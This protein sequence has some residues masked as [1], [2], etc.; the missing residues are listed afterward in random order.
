MDSTAD[1]PAALLERARGAHIEFLAS[2]EPLRPQLYRYCRRLTGNIWDAQDLVQETL[3][4]AFAHAAQSHRPVQRPMA[5]L[6][7]IA[8]NIYIDTLRSAVPVPAELPERA[9]PT[10]T[11]PLE[12]RDALAELSRLLSPQEKACVLLKDVFDLPAK[13]IAAMLSTTQGAVKAALHRGRARLAQEDR[14]SALAARP[15]PDPVVLERLAEAF[16]AYDLDRLAALFQDDAVSEV[17]GVVHEVGLSEIRAGSLQH[18]LCEE[19]DV[20]YRAEVGE[21]EREPV[22]LLWAAPVDGSAGEALVDVL[23]VETADDAVTRLRW[24]FFCPETLVEVAALIRGPV[25]THG[26]HY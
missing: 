1:L 10:D 16:S 15:A 4:R 23:R 18:T 6:A 21:I 20:R 25:R 19:T 3:A 12:V 22:V 26:Y 8:T 9:A 17:V 14:S 24:Y 5:W 2:V 11:D 13:E 7:R